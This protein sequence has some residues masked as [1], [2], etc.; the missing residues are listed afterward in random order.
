MAPIVNPILS[1]FHPDPSLCAV[2]DAFYIATSTFEWY[3]GVEI[4]VSTDCC[5]TWSLVSRPLARASQ[6]DM[7]GN[8]DSCG[9]WA[10]CLSHADGVFWLVYTDVKRYDGQY[11]DTHNYVVT[12]PS[13]DG[14]WSDPV[15]LNSS[16]F[17]PSLFH[18]DEGRK[19]LLNMDWD[20]RGP[21]K[22][23]GHSGRGFFNGILLQEYD[24][25]SKR[26][27]GP[28]I[29]VFPGSS[30][31]LVEGPHLY[32]TRGYYYLICAEGGTGYTHAVTHA[33]SR[34]LAG[35]YEVHPQVHVVTAKDTP[36]AA[37]QRC[38]HGQFAE[39]ADGRVWHSFLCSR[40]LPGCA[41]RRSPC[42][43]ETAIVECEWRDD[44]WLYVKPGGVPAVAKDGF[45]PDAMQCEFP[46][47]Q[48]PRDFQWLRTPHSG[49]IFQV[50]AGAGGTRL[51][52]FGR[53]SIGSWFEQALVARRQT[54]WRYSA[55]TVLEFEPRDYNTMAGLTA[56]Y[57]R[58]QFHYLFVSTNESGRRLL[59]VQSCPG[60]WPE[61]NLNR[62]IGDGIVIPDGPVQL[63]VDVDMTKLQ[64]RWAGADSTWDDVG[65][66]LDAAVLSDEGG[67]GEH[68]NFTGCFVGMAAQDQSGQGHTA[69][70]ASFSYHNRETD[71]EYCCVG[72]STPSCMP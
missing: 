12:A 40:P 39:G 51:R 11:K 47:D 69:D 2:G 52:L 32:K 68:A 58:H 43:R 46:G 65:P 64:F 48:L 41:K 61:G 38:G 60:N 67:R 44:G 72:A 14:P 45:K 13:V 42:G 15:Y 57:N 63:G 21:D 26:L 56:Y 6:L 34:S 27:V 62:P 33:R 24:A 50:G 49:R 4:H 19:W 28:I 25:E 7:R 22:R 53:E 10:P 18:E 8:P 59:S 31:G 3:P 71:L 17:D 55:E 36:D 9:V 54:G 5:Q 66:V 29:N 1:G 23:G 35:P 37:L 30:L 70:F 16:G 20:Y